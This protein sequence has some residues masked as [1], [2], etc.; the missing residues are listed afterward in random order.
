MADNPMDMLGS[1]LSNPDA[2]SAFGKL[3]SG[4]QNNSSDNTVN[5]SDNVQLPDFSSVSDDNG[6]RLLY[7]LEPYLS[8][9]R[10]GN[11]GQIVQ[12]VKI[13]KMISSMNKRK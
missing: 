7:A 12:A 11:L 4:M 9:K 2:V 1:L 3:I 10:R 8:T 5:L 13:G 6:T